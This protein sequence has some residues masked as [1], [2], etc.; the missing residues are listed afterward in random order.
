MSSASR[1]LHESEPI[2]LTPRLR[3]AVR[4]QRAVKF[5][6]EAKGCETESLTKEGLPFRFSTH[7]R[8]LGGNRV[9]WSEGVVMCP[10]KKAYKRC[11]H[12]NTTFLLHLTSWLLLCVVRI[13]FFGIRGLTWMDVTRVDWKMMQGV[14]VVR[15]FG[16]KEMTCTLFL[17]FMWAIFLS[18]NDWSKEMC[19]RQ[20]YHM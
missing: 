5:L 12:S 4:I 19:Q 6:E 9:T 13:V 20:I 14:L 17:F 8:L 15:E 16:R 1:Q 2:R 10:F 3:P 18:H 11:C 7:V